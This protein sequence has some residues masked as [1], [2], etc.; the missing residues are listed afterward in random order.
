MGCNK[1]G[2][3]QERLGMNGGGRRALPGQAHEGAMFL[4]TF[5]NVLLI[6]SITIDVHK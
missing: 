1:V 2:S 6:K 3:Q 5:N 4:H